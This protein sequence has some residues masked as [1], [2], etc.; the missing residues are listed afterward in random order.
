MISFLS[1]LL[2]LQAQ[3][4]Q[5]F[6]FRGL[7]TSSTEQ[8]AVQNGVATRC[9]KHPIPGVRECDLVIHS[10]G[11]SEMLF[12]SVQFRGGYMVRVNGLVQPQN[13]DLLRE[14][15]IKRFG[16]PCLV[17]PSASLMLKYGQTAY[18]CFSDGALSIQQFSTGGMTSFNY[19]ARSYD[20]IIGDLR[21]KVDF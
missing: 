15:F 2:L 5:S 13:F 4:L 12:P 16:A 10:A 17:N 3:E 20:D 21:P 8:W 14:A 9:R 18:W 6:E 11:G 7:T 19:Y 1:A